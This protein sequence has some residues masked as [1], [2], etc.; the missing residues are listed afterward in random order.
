M[1]LLQDL[2]GQ[3]ATSL[4]LCF[5]VDPKT[6]M[7]W[8]DNGWMRT[9]KR[10]GANGSRGK[11]D[12]FYIKDKWVK[13]FIVENVNVIDFRKVDKHWLVSLLTGEDV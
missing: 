13:A 7:R 5:G 2:D 1:Q 10:S 3:S 9:E 6:V 11:W 12:H 8:I 4:A